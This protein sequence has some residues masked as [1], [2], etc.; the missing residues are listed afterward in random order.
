MP[1][2]YIHIYYYQTNFSPF[3][4]SVATNK[5][6]FLQ[7]QD[8]WRLRE[9]KITDQ[10]RVITFYTRFQNP[11]GLLT[12]FFYQHIPFSPSPQT[13]TVKASTIFN[14][15]QQ[16]TLPWPKLVPFNNCPLELSVF[17][18]SH[19]PKPNRKTEP[20]T[21]SSLL[22]HFYYRLYD[23]FYLLKDSTVR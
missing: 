22:W 8:S 19:L 10:S 21:W 15:T 16:V 6:V 7:F 1:T 18:R 9:E 20:Q 17:K 3:L 2:R 12:A 11:S 13:A 4:G 23:F 14:Q 5:V